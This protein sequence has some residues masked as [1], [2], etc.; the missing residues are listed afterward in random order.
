MVHECK[1]QCHSMPL[2]DIE[3]MGIEDHGKWLPFIF[4]MDMVDAAKMSSDEIDSPTYN[5]TTI[6]TKGGDTYII[7]T[8]P[9]DFF[10]KFIEYNNITM[11]DNEDIDPDNDLE[12]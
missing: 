3:N 1:V 11:I 2:S 7:D 9:E 8:L 4:D 6:F 10:R 12:L 5:C